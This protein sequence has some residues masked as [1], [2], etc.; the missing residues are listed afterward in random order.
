[1]A[2]QKPHFL[3]VTYPAQGHIN[4]A[5]RFA[6]RL[7]QSGARVTFSTTVSA[8]RRMEK[9]NSI[10]KDVTFAA[11]S[12]GYDDG[13]RRNVDG[14]ARTYLSAFRQRGSESLRELLEKSA[15]EGNHV[16]CLV[17]TLL[18]PWA[19]EVA[20]SCNVRS[21]LLWIQPAAVFDIYYYCFNGYKDVISECEKDP[22]WCLKLPNLPFEL[23]ARDL[24]S[25]LRPSNC[26]PYT[27]LLPTF[28]EQMEE[29][30]KEET[31]TILVNTFEAL[32]ADMLKSIEK[33]QLVP[34][35]PLLPSAS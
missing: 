33:F 29:L 8:Y 19:S 30:E 14:D 35:G 22:S 27:F 17:Y 32:E 1:M 24:P 31:P 9:G 7:L 28:Q 23:R 18:L 4:P 26:Y 10:P 20:R 6:K 5:L 16:T 11:I 15:A 2:E 25:F 13:F 21:A 3:L 34:V 12:D